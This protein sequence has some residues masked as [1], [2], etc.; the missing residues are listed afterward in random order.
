MIS[1]IRTRIR[2]LSC[3]TYSS[4]C[5]YLFSPLFFRQFDHLWNFLLISHLDLVVLILLTLIA[6]IVEGARHSQERETGATGTVRRKNRSEQDSRERKT[7]RKIKSQSSNI[8]P[9]AALHMRPC[10]AQSYSLIEHFV[11]AN[12]G[13]VMRNFPLSFSTF[14]EQRGRKKEKVDQHL[15]RLLLLPSETPLL[16]LQYI[17]AR[18]S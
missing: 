7:L 18:I 8:V 17:H 9:A 6:I 10:I 4:L 16:L 1:H 3:F 2:T 14:D 11:S 12:F 5:V 13:P 15:F